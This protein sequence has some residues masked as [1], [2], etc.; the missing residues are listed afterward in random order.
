M[1]RG[2]GLAEG[3][4]GGHFFWL[5]FVVDGVFLGV[6]EEMEVWGWRLEVGGWR[7]VVEIGRSWV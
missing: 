1:Q 2:E 3:G 4:F 5:C 6:V 7:S